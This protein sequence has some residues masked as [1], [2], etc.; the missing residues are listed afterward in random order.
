LIAEQPISIV[1][2]NELSVSGR[3][4]VGSPPQKAPLTRADMTTGLWIYSTA[5]I[6]E[7]LTSMVSSGVPYYYECVIFVISWMA[8]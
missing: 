1:L 2:K 5:I 3:K 6:A 4:L 7:V 8:G